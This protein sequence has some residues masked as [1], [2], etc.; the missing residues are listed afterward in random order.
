MDAPVLHKPHP[1][2]FPLM[3]LGGV[4]G[5]VLVTA[6]L[7]LAPSLGATVVD[8]PRLIGGVFAR[9][10]ATRFSLGYTI[11]MLIGILVLPLAMGL[12]WPVL[13][14][15]RFTF[16]GA[17]VKAAIFAIALAAVTGVLLPLL[18]MVNDLPD[19]RFAGPGFFGLRQGLS[20][21][22]QLL[23]GELLYALA[24]AVVAAMGRG[25]GPADAI[26]WMWTSH[27]SGESP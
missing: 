26:G 18:E 24:V 25:L 13:P 10:P 22:L 15:D 27:G 16:R 17:L 23:V 6:L 1:A 5:T 19:D 9:D 11:F 12:L 3:V 20:G 14:G 4:T 2:L 7:Q 8:L 21:P